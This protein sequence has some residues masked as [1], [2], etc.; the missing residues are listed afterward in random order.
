MAATTITLGDGFQLM[1]S[2]EADTIGI[3]NWETLMH[4]LVHAKEKFDKA[5]ADGR[6]SWLDKLRLAGLSEDLLQIIKRGKLLV[7]EAESFTEEEYNR[8]YAILDAG[9][10]FN[11]KVDELFA[12][13]LAI[14]RSIS[15]LADKIEPTVEA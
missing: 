13:L 9:F 6:I 11:G 8:L 1:V 10:Q 4:F 5:A 3:E 15:G 2:P 14:L 12:S 7:A